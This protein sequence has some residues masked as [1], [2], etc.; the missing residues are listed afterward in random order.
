MRIRNLLQTYSRESVE[1]GKAFVL[2]ENERNILKKLYRFNASP[3]N[4]YVTY[5]AR[6]IPGVAQT[7]NLENGYRYIFTETP[8]TDK[9][10]KEWELEPIFETKG[11]INRFNELINENV[12]NSKVSSYNDVRKGVKKD[13]ISRVQSSIREGINKNDGQSTKS[14]TENG[15]I[16]R[17]NRRG[18][19]SQ[20]KLD[21]RN[22]TSSIHEH[23]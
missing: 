17:G 13:D 7:D 8:L 21:Q 18:I 23:A 12:D 19:Q 3:N 16:Q 9:F 6:T 15:T 5:N 4:V 22:S 14:T 2:K 11:R 10:I 20:P 1:S